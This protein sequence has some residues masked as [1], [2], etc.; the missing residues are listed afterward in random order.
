MTNTVSFVSGFYQQFNKVITITE[1]NMIV[2]TDAKVFSFNFDCPKYV[3]E[4]SK[5]ETKFIMKSNQ[6]LA[7]NKMKSDIEQLL[8]KFKHGDT[9]YEQEKHQNE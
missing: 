2:I 8:L 5:H 3:D 7:E 6:S 9:I 4:N 1:E